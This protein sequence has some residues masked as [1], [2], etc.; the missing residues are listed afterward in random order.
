MMMFLMHMILIDRYD[1]DADDNDDIREDESRTTIPM[2]TRPG[3]PLDG[4]RKK[5]T[6]RIGNR[7]PGLTRCPET[8][9]PGGAGARGP[10]APEPKDPGTPGNE[11]TGPDGAGTRGP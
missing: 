10:E 2:R 6:E 4:P 1:N 9:A 8:W 3:E 7:V 5:M 11:N